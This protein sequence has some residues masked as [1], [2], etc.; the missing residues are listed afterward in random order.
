YRK[1][2]VLRLDLCDYTSIAARL[3]PLQVA[4][5]IHQI[6][7][8]LD[9]AVPERRIFKLDTI[10]DEYICAGWLEESQERLVCHM[11]MALA[12]TMLSVV[13]VESRKAG[14]RISCRI[15]IAVGSCVAGTMGK[16]QPRF[17]AIGEAMYLAQSL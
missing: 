2:V 3:E 12:E 8:K 5:L 17:Q 14:Q 10:G 15:G 7:S 16:Q 1:A 9:E 6:Y 4:T 13:D 11:M